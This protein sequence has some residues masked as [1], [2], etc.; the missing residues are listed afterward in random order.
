MW[1]KIEIIWLPVTML[2]SRA[3]ARA[4]GWAATEQFYG[5]LQ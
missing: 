5:F 4:A 3:N 2:I 1:Q